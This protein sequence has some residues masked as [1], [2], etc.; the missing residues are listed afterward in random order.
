MVTTTEA[1][2]L[3]PGIVRFLRTMA[4]A[5]HD[6]NQVAAFAEMAS[7]V[8]RLAEVSPRETPADPLCGQLEALRLIFLR[9][10]IIPRVHGD[11]SVTHGKN[12]TV[13]LT[14]MPEAT[15]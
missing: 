13:P 9:A 11:P 4:C 1:L 14:A 12:G 6:R 7:A 10:G 3:S 2:A 15:R 5:S 8:E